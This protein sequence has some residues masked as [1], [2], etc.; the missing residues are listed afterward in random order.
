MERACRGRIGGRGTAFRRMCRSS[1]PSA[2]ARPF[3]TNGPCSLLDVRKPVADSKHPLP[4]FYTAG[5]FFSIFESG[6]AFL[7]G[8]MAG[9]ASSASSLTARAEIHG[10][11][12][13]LGLSAAKYHF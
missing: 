4:Q 7:S 2:A 3:T 6:V 11:A 5:L 12:G 10:V 1:A 9:I 13:V 8:F